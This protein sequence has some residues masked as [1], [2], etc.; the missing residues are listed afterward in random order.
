MSRS[1]CMIFE[2]IGPYNAIGKIAM[3]EVRAALGAGFHVSVVADR[4]DESLRDHVQW[5]KLYRPPRGF[6]LQWLTARR[7]IRAALGNRQFDVVHA[8][9]PQAASLADVFQCHFLTRVAYETKTL[10][11]RPGLRARAVR[12]QQQIVLYA[13]DHFYRRWNPRTRMLYNSQ[14]TQ[15]DFHRLYGPLPRE[16]VFLYPCPPLDL[17]SPAERRAARAKLIGHEYSGPMVGYLGGIQERKG[18]RQL[19]SALEGDNDIFLLLAGQYTEGFE[20][21]RLRGRSKAFG[22]LSDTRTFYAACDAFVVPSIYE[23][24]GLVAFEAAVRGAPVILSPA[25]GAAPHLTAYGAGMTWQHDQPLVPLVRQ[26]VRDRERMNNGARQM[27]QE[28]G[29]EQHAQRLLRIYEKVMREGRG[30]RTGTGAVDFGG[31]TSPFRGVSSSQ[32]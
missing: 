24:F 5:L 20:M 21:P 28:N 31:A 17:P 6:A 30:S 10:E 29:E 19:I 11:S 18:Y 22:L 13:E 9:Q 23:S 27:A 7:F 2:G 12:A 26:A 15:R 25:V 4:L 1:L 14:V 16:E 32:P 3:A 8:H